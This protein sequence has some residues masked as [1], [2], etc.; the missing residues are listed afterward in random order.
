MHFDRGLLHRDDGPAVH[1]SDSR[2]TEYYDKGRFLM[3]KTAR[4][5]HAEF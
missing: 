1:S 5:I 3:M 2:D 4:S